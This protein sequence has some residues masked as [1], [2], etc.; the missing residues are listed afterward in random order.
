MHLAVGDRVQFASGEHLRERALAGAV[1]P[2]D[3]VHFAR[4]DGEVDALE[5]F[6]VANRRVQVFD[7]E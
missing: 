6:A 5:N 7:F 3:G 1:R 4:V 2:H